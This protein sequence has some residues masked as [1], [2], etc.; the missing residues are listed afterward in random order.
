M[1]TEN[2]RHELLSEMYKLRN[3]ADRALKEYW[4]RVVLLLNSEKFVNMVYRYHCGE[5]LSE[6]EN[7]YFYGGK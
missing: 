4:A 7:E 5:T 3:E 1:I 2:K 6:L